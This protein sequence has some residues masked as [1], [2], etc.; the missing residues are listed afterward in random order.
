[1]VGCGT[2]GSAMAVLPEPIL[3]CAA[4]MLEQNAS[5]A[6]NEMTVAASFVG[7]EVVTRTSKSWCKDLQLFGVVRAAKAAVVEEFSQ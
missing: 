6:S 7:W 5:S 1:M 4:A 2:G 3:N